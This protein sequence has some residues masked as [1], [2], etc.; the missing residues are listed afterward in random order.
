MLKLN[1]WICS[2]KI[3]FFYPW[4]FLVVVS[5]A[6]DQTGASKSLL[7]FYVSQIR[8]LVTFFY[9]LLFSL[10]RIYGNLIDGTVIL[11]DWL[12]SRKGN[13][14]LRLKIF[15]MIIFI[16]YVLG[17]LDLNHFFFWIIS[18]WVTKKI[19]PKQFDLNHFPTISSLWII[20]LLFTKQK[21]K[22]FVLHIKIRKVMN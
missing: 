4:T 15:M 1:E 17:D 16:K 10:L 14:L 18:I 5:R 13:D 22:K 7:W 11:G 9:Y 2:K 8:Q 3:L 6:I 19:H 21:K 20:Q 12:T